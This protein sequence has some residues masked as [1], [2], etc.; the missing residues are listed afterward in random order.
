M[1]R[2]FAELY[3]RDDKTIK[4]QI[5]RYLGVLERYYELFPDCKEDVQ[6]FST[7]GRTEV[8]AIIPITIMDGCW[9]PE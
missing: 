7:P 3:G 1:D 9:Q 4:R 8:G 2:L 5:N 6:F